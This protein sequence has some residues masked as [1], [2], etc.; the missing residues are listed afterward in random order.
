M[1]VN[2]NS[3]VGAIR[4]ADIAPHTKQHGNTRG[5]HFGLDLNLA[6]IGRLSRSRNRNCGKSGGCQLDRKERAHR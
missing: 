3:A 6:E 2:K 5:Q 4:H 1:I